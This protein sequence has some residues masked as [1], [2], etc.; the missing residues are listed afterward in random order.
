MY[1]VAEGAGQAVDAAVGVWRYVD[2]RYISILL[3]PVVTGPSLDPCKI[4]IR[5][6]D[7]CYRR[8]LPS[9]DND[10]RWQDT[11]ALYSL[12]QPGSPGLM[13]LVQGSGMLH[14]GSGILW[15]RHC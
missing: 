7:S 12:R 8:V 14:E 6:A 9:A 13:L 11:V 15:S 4:G 2:L 1:S 5:L 3:R 10:P